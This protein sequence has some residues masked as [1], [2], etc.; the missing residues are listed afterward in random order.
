MKNKVAYAPITFEEIV[1]V[2][3]MIIRVTNN[4]LDN[5]YNSSVNGQNDNDDDKINSSRNASSTNLK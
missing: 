3:I 1:T 5:T 2:M 4:Y